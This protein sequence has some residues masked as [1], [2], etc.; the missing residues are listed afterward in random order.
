MCFC[1]CIHAHI[2]E[3]IYMCNIY[4]YTCLMR[5]YMCMY[6][7][8]YIYSQ[9]GCCNIPYEDGVNEY[10]LSAPSE[11]PLPLEVLPYR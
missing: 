4:I 9:L 8:I 1:E 6:T 3:R 7:Y 10:I 11:R 2:Y 5:A